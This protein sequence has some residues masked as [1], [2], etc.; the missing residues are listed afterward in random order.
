MVNNY[1]ERIILA[2]LKK[3]ENGSSGII[4]GMSL[5]SCVHRCRLRLGDRQ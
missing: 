5:L 4:E 1:T 2:F 3:S